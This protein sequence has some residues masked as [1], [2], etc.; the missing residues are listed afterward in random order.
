MLDFMF[1]L[2]TSRRCTGSIWEFVYEFR[3]QYEQ[4]KDRQFL[5]LQ[6]KPLYRQNPENHVYAVRPELESGIPEIC[7]KSEKQLSVIVQLS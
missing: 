3:Y 2:L 5:E 7:P 1:N 6:L 4:K